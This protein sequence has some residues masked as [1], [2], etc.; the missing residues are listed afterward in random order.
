MPT[1]TLIDDQEKTSIMGCWFLPVNAGLIAGF[2]QLTAGIHLLRDK[3]HLEKQEVAGLPKY[4][5]MKER[6]E[7]AKP[8][9]HASQRT[10]LRILENKTKRIFSPSNHY[11]NVASIIWTLRAPVPEVDVNSKPTFNPANPDGGEPLAYWGFPRLLNPHRDSMIVAGN[12]LVLL[13][14]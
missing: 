14:K 1:L 2:Y 8:A 5:S 11:V 12:A 13:W 3:H 7:N 10:L 6:K 4:K 9:V